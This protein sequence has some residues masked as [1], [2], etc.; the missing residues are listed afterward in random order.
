M[1]RR[2]VQAANGPLDVAFPES[3]SPGGASGTQMFVTEEGMAM[4]VRLVQPRKVPS[5][6]VV[7]LNGMVTQLRLVQPAKVYFLK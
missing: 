7:T 2:L 6:T 3:K 4:D 1:A 5:S